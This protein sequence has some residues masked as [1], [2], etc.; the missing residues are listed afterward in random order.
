MRAK[1]QPAKLACEGIWDGV[2]QRVRPKRWSRALCCCRL[3]VETWCVLQDSAD[4]PFLF[5]LE[6]S[7]VG[8]SRARPYRRHGG[9]A[10]ARTGV[11]YDGL[12]LWIRLCCVDASKK[13]CKAPRTL[14]MC[15]A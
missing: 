4:L 5:L 6:C 2:S 11:G 9:A 13:A 15:L 12:A 3:T 8:G 1:P 10:A 7:S 14:Q